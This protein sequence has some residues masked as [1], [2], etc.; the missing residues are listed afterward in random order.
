MQWLGGIHCCC[1][2]DFHMKTMQNMTIELGSW[3]SGYLARVSNTM[4]NQLYG[5]HYAVNELCDELSAYRGKM[6]R[7]SLVLLAWKSASGDGRQHHGSVVTMA[8]VVEMIHLATL[9]HDDVLDEA[10]LR[11]G[12]RTIHSLCG[13]EAAVMLGDYLLSSAFHLCSTLKNPSLNILLGEVTSTV[14]AGEMMQL[15]HRNNVDLDIETYY[16]IIHDKTAS[17]ITASC[18]IGGILAGASGQMLSALKTFGSSVG[19]AFQIRDDV[20]DLLGEPS[21]TGKTTGVDLEK[22]KLTLPVISMLHHNPDLKHRVQETITNHDLDGLGELLESTGSIDFAIQEIDRRVDLAL[23]S[24][25][26]AFSA[27]ASRELCGLVEQLKQG[28]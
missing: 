19:I 4:S 15:H 5:E 28:L 1:K 9:V 20:L 6:L 21:V 23:K 25:R 10:D 13:N 7:P 11:R 14:C 18:V 17:L 27:H 24:V 8:T 2:I 26:G 12:E 22:G 3:L 16:Q